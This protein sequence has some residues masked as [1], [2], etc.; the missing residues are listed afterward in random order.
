MRKLIIA[1]IEII[2]LQVLFFV[3][4]Y[5]YSGSFIRG[6]CFTLN[7]MFTFVVIKRLEKVYYKN[8]S[9]KLISLL[10]M[11]C[12]LIGVSILS[13]ISYVLTKDLLY[14][15]YYIPMFIGIYIVNII[16]LIKNHIYK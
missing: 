3:L 16:Y 13:Y 12:P 14:V 15:K 1:T 6:A 9:K 5:I 4:P 7:I 8:K 10:Y 11:I 2:L